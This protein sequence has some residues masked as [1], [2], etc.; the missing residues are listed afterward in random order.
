M[1]KLSDIH[2]IE[3]DNYCF[4]LNTEVP[5]EKKDGGT[6]SKIIQTFHNTIDQACAYALKKHPDLRNSKDI[7]EC[8]ERMTLISQQMQTNVK[9]YSENIQVIKVVPR[10]EKGKKTEESEDVIDD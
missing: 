10:K 9:E 4:I 6:G 8:V 1:I 2:A 5:T 3:A 7:Q